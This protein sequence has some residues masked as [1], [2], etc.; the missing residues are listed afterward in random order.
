MDC[1]RA[2]FAGRVISRFGHMAW[3]AMSP[4][5]N[6]PDLL[7]LGT[8]ESQSVCEQ[9]WKAWGADRAYQG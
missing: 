2:V 8:L 9:T 6:V 4:D 5:L 7:S 1:L 3:P